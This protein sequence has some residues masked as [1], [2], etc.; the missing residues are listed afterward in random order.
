MKSCEWNTKEELERRGHDKKVKHEVEL[1]VFAMG[2]KSRH[3]NE[4][5]A[6][7]MSNHLGLMVCHEEFVMTVE[8]L[9]GEVELFD[10][11]CTYDIHLCTF[12]K[13]EMKRMFVMSDGGDFEIASGD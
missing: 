12:V 9:R 11:V 6:N 10:G 1:S 3:S 13:H 2:V 4:E 8:F 7:C 5:I